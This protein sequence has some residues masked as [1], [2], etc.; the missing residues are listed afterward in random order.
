[1][2]SSE[3]KDIQILS[4]FTIKKPGAAFKEL[5]VNII[6]PIMILTNLSSE[7]RLGI[8][9]AL[10]LAFLLPLIYGLNDYIKNKNTN[11]FSILGIISV[12]LSGGLAL[13][14]ADAIYIAIK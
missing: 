7:D 8:K 9:L 13:L 14:E 6:I 12:S 11:F 5:L 3:N 1:M 2:E 4:E 10:F